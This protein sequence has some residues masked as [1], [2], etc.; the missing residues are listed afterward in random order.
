MNTIKKIWN[1]IKGWKTVI[2]NLIVAVIPILELAQ[3]SDILPKQMTP[4]YIISVAM[5]NIAIRAATN[6]AIGKAK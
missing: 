2:I 4:Y 6:T 3:W 1:K 5:L